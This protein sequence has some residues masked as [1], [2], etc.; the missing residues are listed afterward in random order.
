MAE[1]AERREREDGPTAEDRP[2]AGAPWIAAEESRRVMEALT[3]GGRPARFVGGCVRDALLDPGADPHDVDIATAEPPERV[4]ELL[5][6]AGI[7]TIPTGLAHGTVTALAGERSFEITTLRRDVE[8]YGRHARVQYSDSFEEDAARRDFTINAMSAD[9]EGRVYDY[10]GGRADLAAGRVRFVG[11]AR[12]RIREDYLRILRF[13][14]FFARFGRPPADAEALEAIE[15]EAAGLDRLSGERIREELLRLLMAP[16]ASDS[17]RLMAETGVLARILP[18]APD[19]DTFER[20][21]AL[22]PWA[23]PILRLAALLRHAG[24]DAETVEALAAR[25]RLSNRER[26]D[27]AFLLLADLPDCTESAAEHRARAWRSGPERYRRLL[28][29]AAALRQVPRERFAAALATVASFEPP[30]FPVRGADLVR[31]GLRPGPRVGGLLREL[32]DLWV[33]SDFRL[34]REE[35]LSEARRRMAEGGGGGG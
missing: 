10:F 30:A 23:D 11:R 25:L 8:T 19:I 7:R 18:A 28:A 15:A 20:L 12:E 13:F 4:M 16:R 32:E 3:A 5:E 29:L 2:L 21:V 33:A 24:P 34:G 31:M 22:A 9:L 14:R 6:R 1:A 35:L 17:L 26:D 27:L